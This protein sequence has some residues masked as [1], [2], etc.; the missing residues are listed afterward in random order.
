MIGWESVP[1]AVATGSRV[2]C[3]EDATHPVANAPD[4]YYMGR[5][6]MDNGV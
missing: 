3:T 5:E 1:G 6:P 4:T 2:S